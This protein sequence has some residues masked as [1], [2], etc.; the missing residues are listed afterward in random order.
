MSENNYEIQEFMNLVPKD[1]GL[2]LDLGHLNISSN[3]LDFN[4]NNFLEKFIELY[5]NRLLEV[6]ISENN[7]IKDEH[8]PLEKSSWQLEA[9]KK[10]N[11][12]KTSLLQK[13]VYCLEA[14][15]SKSEGLKNSLFLINEIIN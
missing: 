2:L 3:L 5:G 12:V 1:V 9:I 15:N 14:R 4:R 6:H 8:L 7:G 10:I 11:K 13:R